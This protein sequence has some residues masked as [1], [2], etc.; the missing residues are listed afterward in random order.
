MFVTSCLQ[1]S[2]FYSQINGKKCRSGNYQG[3][4]AKLEELAPTGGGEATL[5]VVIGN[6]PYYQNFGECPRSAT[7]GASSERDKLDGDLC[8]TPL[9]P[10]SILTGPEG[11]GKMLPNREGAAGFVVE[12]TR[13]PDERTA[14][15]R[16]A[17]L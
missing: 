15:R 5:P 12:A 14:M 7:C 3:G 6:V 9:W 13:G 2:R 10:H 4:L 8:V 1:R 16:V 11:K 17:R